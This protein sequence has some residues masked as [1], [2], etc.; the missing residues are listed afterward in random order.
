MEKHY[1]ELREKVEK[2]VGRK[3]DAPRDFDYLST[4]ILGSVNIYVAP[5]TLK[6]FWD[7]LARRGRKCL[8]ATRSIFLHSMPAT[9]ISM[10]FVQGAVK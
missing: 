1:A 4:R 8:T 2:V 10:L 5:V 3:M 9:R 7:I 6:R